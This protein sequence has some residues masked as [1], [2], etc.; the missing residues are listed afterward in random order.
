M[1]STLQQEYDTALSWLD[2]ASEL[3]VKNPDVSSNIHHSGFKII[4][5]Y[6]ILNGLLETFVNLPKVFCV[7]GRAGTERSRGTIKAIRVLQIT[8]N[9]QH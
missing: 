2:K 9:E 5:F 4:K 8:S 7:L 1:P 3:P 6:I